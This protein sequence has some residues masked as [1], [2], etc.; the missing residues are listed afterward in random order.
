MKSQNAISSAPTAIESER[1]DMVGCAREKVHYVIVR[2]DLPSGIAGA[3]IVHAAGE[4]G[5]APPGTIAILLRVAD[6]NELLAVAKLVKG[7]HMIIECEGPYA[8]QALA[9]G[10]PPGDRQPAL[11]RLGLWRGGSV[12]P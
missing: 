1:T 4:T 12:L 11:G 6:E 10:V 9:F 8:G 7:A 2:R 5:P 3:M